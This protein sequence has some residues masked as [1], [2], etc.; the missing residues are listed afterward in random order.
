MKIAFVIPW[1]QEQIPGG[2]EAELRGY[3]HKLIEAGIDVEILTTRVKEFTADWNVNYYP[4]GCRQESGI[5]IHRFNVRKRDT[6]KFGAVNAKLMSDE[7]ISEAEEEIFMR[8][9]VNSPDLCKYIK[10]KHDEY[11]LFVFIPYMFG[12]TYYGMLE[13]LDKAVMIPCFHDE[14]YV[15]MDIYKNAFEYAAG[16]IYNAEAEKR[17]AN[18]IFNLSGSEQMVLG[19]GIDTEYSYDADGFRNKYDIHDPFILYAGRKDVG[20][21]I[22]LLI[23]YFREY[24]KRHHESQLKLVL[25]GGGEVDLPQD[26]KKEVIDLGFVDKQDKYDACAASIALCQPSV[27]ESFSIVIMES[28]LSE[29]PV[30]VHE[31]CEVTTDFVK[32][33]NGGLYF[34]NYYDFEGCINYFID[35]P[36]IA[37]KMGQNGR[38]YVLNNFAWKIVVNRMIKFFEV[39]INKGKDNG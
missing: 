35:N 19:V 21:N 6:E 16:F 3:V 36:E 27:H 29:R 31:K 20:K 7:K 9:M 38:K 11:D 15:Y 25:I 26:I 39:I 17:L 30:L 28:W 33:S 4:E 2:A 5:T 13:C 22:Y 1:Y 8:E 34:K 24:K 37:T 18:K 23:K 10:D 14:S 32:N 12:T